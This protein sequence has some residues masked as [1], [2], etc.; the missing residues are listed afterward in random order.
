MLE[1]L[2]KEKCLPEILD[3]YEEL[4]S[5]RRDV[6]A[7]PECGF[8]TVE[9]IKKI[10]EFLLKHGIPS[11]DI[12]NKSA[13]GSLFVSIQGNKP[14]K[15]IALRADVDALQMTDQSGK[16]WSSEIEG[17]AH[18]CGH[19]GH[20]SW[21]MGTAVYLANHRDFAGR[22]ICLF[23]A[24]E[25]I[26]TGAQSVVNSGF[27]EKYDIKEIYAGH[28]EP[29]LQKGTVG[30]KVGHIQAASDRFDVK[31]T[32]SGTHGGR[33]H[34]GNDPIPALSELY[35][36]LQTIVSRKV[37][38]LES[39]VVSVCYMN[40]G[41]PGTYN[42]VPGT[43]ELGGTVRT[44]LPEIRDLVEVNVKRM[45]EGVALTHGLKSELQYTRLVAS[46]NNEKKVTEAAI[47]VAQELLGKDHVVTDMDASMISEDFAVYQEKI[48]GTIFFI[49]MRDEEHQSQL[50]N[51]KFD[52]NDEILPISATLFVK[53][54]LSRL[55]ALAEQI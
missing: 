39:A 5:H 31:L 4:V 21:M 27:I 8:E 42:V 20:Q 22:V 49:G 29:F 34:Q 36:A 32:G 45:V 16:D 46:V 12:D 1:P 55:Q 10:K 51:P 23:Q 53:I 30:F 47:K 35:Q 48:P 43:A 15:T 3:I 14:G 38:P 28:D 50:H 18:A 26:C 41:T 19:D 9:T 7:H 52:F 37:N 54:A 33:P 40:A 2:A 25:E 24:A 17:H 13:P 44:F 6:H 11:S